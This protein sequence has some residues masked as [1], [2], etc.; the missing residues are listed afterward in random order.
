M[1]RTTKFHSAP[2][3]IFPVR[4]QSLS[5]T[6]LSTRL[7]GWLWLWFWLLLPAGLS[8]GMEGAEE[9]L[10]PVFSHPLS[11]MASESFELQ[12]YEQAVEYT[13]QAL[14]AADLGAGERP[15]VLFLR[16]LALSRV[17]RPQ[18]AEGVLCALSEQGAPPELSAHVA[19]FRMKSYAGRPGLLSSDELKEALALLAKIPVTGRFG[20]QAA[21]LAVRWNFSLEQL[22]EGCQRAAALTEQWKGEAAESDALLLLADCQER[23]ALRISELGQGQEALAWL[24]R[25]VST[26]GELALWWPAAAATKRVQRSLRGLLRRGARLAAPN[27]EKILARA[28]LITQRSRSRVTLQQLSRMRRF[29]PECVRDSVSHPTCQELDLLSARI[30]AVLRDFRSTERFYR[31]VA[32]RPASYELGARAEFGLAEVLSRRSL[33][34]AR[35]AFLAVERRWPRSASATA[36][37]YEAG[38]LSRRIGD[39]QGASAAFQRCAEPFPDRP[40]A[41]QCRWGLGWLAWRSR[42]PADA[43]LWLQDLMVSEATG[44][45]ERGSEAS[46]S[47]DRAPAESEQAA[48]MPKVRYWHARILEKDGEIGAASRA[49]RN[50]ARDYPYGYYALMASERLSTLAP[51]TPEETLAGRPSGQAVAPAQGLIQVHHPDILAAIAY[52]RM[53]LGGEAR[54]TL[55]SLRASRLS[56][57][58][59]RAASLAWQG[60]GDY[61][62]ARRIAPSPGGETESAE[63]RLLDARL[64]YPKAFFEEVEGP[65]R[66]AAVPASLLFALIRTESDFSPRAR[67]VAK[68]LGL[69]Q[70]I[71]STAEHTARLLSLTDFQFQKLVEPEVAVQI[72]SAYLGQL[73]TLFDSNVVLAVAAYNAGERSVARWVARQDELPIDVFVEEIPFEETNRYVRNVLSSYA[74][75]RTL[76]SASDGPAMKIPLSISHDLL[77]KLATTFPP[78]KSTRRTELAAQNPD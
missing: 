50:L 41:A 55:L 75:Y 47:E 44:A 40:A 36:A 61:Q 9:T 6:H 7:V 16:Y 43:L 64:S 21:A 10:V 66:A 59:R 69:T 2:R 30:A 23:T 76:Y 56:R 57:A 35:D 33:T 52:L 29:I 11:V 1:Q 26:Y 74:A 25:A 17:N 12:Q 70:V 77:V 65:Q 19:W 49:Y 71:R 60:L 28:R 5:V 63:E 78:S 72:G 27:P 3:R 39:P 20:P 42:R 48:L 13:G 22:D 8:D 54:S 58:E 32:S 18:E 14:G 45:L 67:S 53:G 4:K 62:Q 37:L 38:E 51:G 15:Y 24:N 73:L 34:L 68:A 46:G 31:Q